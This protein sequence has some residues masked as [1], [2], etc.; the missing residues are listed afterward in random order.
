MVL[1]GG[2]EGGVPVTAR[3]QAGLLEGERLPVIAW[4]HAVLLQEGGVPVKAWCQ[5]ELGYVEGGG[6]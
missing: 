5:A 4:C 2:Q 1:G 6:G 3:C